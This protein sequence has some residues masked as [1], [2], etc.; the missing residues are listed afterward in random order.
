M[1]DPIN[2]SSTTPRYNLPVLFPGQ[3]QKEFFVNQ[4]HAILD[5]IIQP[6]IVGMANT[7]PLFP[8]DGDAWIVLAP[9]EGSWTGHENAIATFA[10]GQWLFTPPVEGMQAFDRDT[11]RRV[12]YINGWTYA[13]EPISPNGGNMIDVEA[14]TAIEQIIGALRQMGVFSPA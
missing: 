3:A 14:R 4:A 1:A 6:V 5:T 11:S 2:F 9:A 8:A 13:E 7:A 12:Y 10:A